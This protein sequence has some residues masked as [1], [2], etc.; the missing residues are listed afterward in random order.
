MKTLVSTLT[1][2]IL[3]HLNG[4]VST[5]NIERFSNEEIKCTLQ[6]RERTKH[7]KYLVIEYDTSHLLAA[8]G[9][10]GTNCKKKHVFDE[11]SGKNWDIFSLKKETS[12]KEIEIS[13]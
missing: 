9:K 6:C 7:W 8:S 3:V 2:G 13:P 1:T 12:V 4:T 5:S 10:T 11:G